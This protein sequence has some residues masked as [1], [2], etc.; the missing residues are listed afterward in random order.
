MKRIAGL[1]ICMALVFGTALAEQAVILPGGRYVIEVPDDM[2]YSVPE[3]GDFGVEAYISDML[4]MDYLSFPRT[5]GSARGMAET[6]RET[7][8]ACSEKK[9]DVELRKVKDTELLCFR[10]S[11]EADGASCI[12]YVFE[13]GEQYIE[14]D[15]WYATPEA[16]ERTA[17]IIS[18]LRKK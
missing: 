12:G 6:L 16:A 14:V 13:D 8:E 18:T 7:E 2:E 11:D 5:E 10:T 3:D 9:M 15:F 1:L 4:E 17:Q